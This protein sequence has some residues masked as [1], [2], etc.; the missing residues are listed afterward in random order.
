MRATSKSLLKHAW[1]DSSKTYNKP[2]AYLRRK[3]LLVEFYG[4]SPAPFLQRDF[5]RQNMFRSIKVRVCA[6]V[7]VRASMS[8]CFCV[9]VLCC[10]VRLCLDVLLCIILS[11]RVS[12]QVCMWIEVTVSK[13]FTCML[14]ACLTSIFEGLLCKGVGKHDSG[15]YIKN[16]HV[17][18]NFTCLWCKQKSHT[19]K[20]EYF[21]SVIL[22]WEPWWQQDLGAY[23]PSRPWS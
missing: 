17:A 10:S 16:I 2:L 21:W 8:V 15:V 23:C 12:V 4:P 3:L 11:R 14:A 18:L 22:T 1:L 20:A 5:I 9:C 13:M 6:C 19:H 7:N